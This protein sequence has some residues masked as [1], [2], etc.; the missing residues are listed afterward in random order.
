MNCPK[1]PKYKGKRLPKRECTDCLNLYYTLKAP[2]APHKPTK[3]FK[4][5]SKY[6]RKQKHKEKTDV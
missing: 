6:T 3:V 2:R 5:K 4:D 1:H